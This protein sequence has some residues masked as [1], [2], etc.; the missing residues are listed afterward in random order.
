MYRRINGKTIISILLC[1]GIL[2][3]AAGYSMLSTNLEITAGASITTTWDVR[4]TKITTKNISGSAYNIDEP[5]FTNDTA[6]FS[7]ALTD[8]GDSITYTI[9]IEN[10]GTITA[11]LNSLDITTNGT[12]Q[13]IYEVTGIKE[14]DI[15]T[16]GNSV[17]V[18]VVAR[19]NSNATEAPEDAG[20]SLEFGLNWMQYTNQ[21]ISAGTYTI[22]YNANGGS[23]SMSGTTCTVG[24]NCTLSSNAFTRSGY[25]FLGWSTD[26][27]GAHVYTDGQSVKN[28]TSSGKTLTLYAIWKQNNTLVNAIFRDN[29]AY[30]D[31]VSSPYVTSSTGIDFSQISSDT[32]G[33]GLY[34]TST[35]TENNQRTY[36]FR[37]AV[38]NN[39]VKFG[40]ITVT[41]PSHCTYEGEN[42]NALDSSITSKEM[43]ESEPLCYSQGSY[44]VT[45]VDICVDMIGGKSINEYA[46]WAEGE[47]KNVDNLW[48]IVRINEDGSIRIVTQDSVGYSA[49]NENWDDNAY[50]GYMYGTPRSTTYAATHANTN[51][52]TIKAYIDDW[53]VNNL[54]SYSSYL[55]DAG[56]CNDR[57]VAPSA[58][59]WYSSDTALG[60]ANNSTLYGAHNRL[61]N[62]K[63]PQFAC[64]NASNDLF[65]TNTS[66][67]GN[68]TLTNPIGL[69]TA[70]EVAYVGAALYDPDESGYSKSIYTWTMSPNNYANYFAFMFGQ[71]YN[72]LKT[73]GV[74]DDFEIGVRPVI[75]LKSTVTLS[76]TNPS[77]CSS[78]NGT[79][80]CPYVIG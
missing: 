68:K 50:V 37:G 16:A 52:S 9:T 13:I 51:D 21:S 79:A 3:M 73:W 66:S 61:W 67:K 58:G 49:F 8:P 31:N 12:S 48:R 40:Q 4:I 64:P 34:Y 6:R 43:C 17:E 65:T 80:S 78:Q 71:S 1:L 2:F 45:S 41:S 39:Y 28:L 22:N 19:Y 77:G 24:S 5:D 38:E 46:T 29:T 63:K 72:D 44:Y 47:K 30:A 60:Y 36:Y 27:L 15:L 32:N 74:H 76:S 33:K 75:N 35:N 59:L 25:K 62:N 18:T 55:A 23:G 11:I 54:S 14:G 57:S 7:L 53:Y 20:K 70:D 56:F 10:K 69:L 26:T 42:V